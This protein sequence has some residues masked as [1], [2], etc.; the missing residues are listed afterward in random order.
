MKPSTY[1][2]VRDCVENGIRYGIRRAHKHTDEPSEDLLESEIYSAIVTELDERLES[3]IP[4][5]D[6]YYEK[7]CNI[8][9]RRVAP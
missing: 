2:I 1:N 7:E 3:E 9:T 5:L 6:Q 4:T 8:E